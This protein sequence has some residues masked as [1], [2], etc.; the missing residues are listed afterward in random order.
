MSGGGP[1]S[2]AKKYSLRSTGIWEKIRKLLVLVPD[3]STGNPLVPLYRVPSTGSRPEAATYTDPTTLPASDIADNQYYNRDTRRAYP[4]IAIYSQSDIGGLLLYGS[5]AKPR[6]A[7][8]DAGEKALTTIKDGSLSLTDA[9]KKSPKDIIFGEILDKDGL[10]PF[11]TPLRK[12][13]KWELLT[14]TESG[15]YNEQYPVRTFH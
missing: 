14:E 7:K 15:M 9:I 6:I 2:I 1:V 8:G 3:R 10:P 12:N 5:A 13:L 11:P 4:R